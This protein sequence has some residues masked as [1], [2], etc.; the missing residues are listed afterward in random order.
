MGNL[1]SEA[2]MLDAARP[3]IEAG[4]AVHWLHP[5]TKRPVG[6]KWADKPVHTMES[7]AAAYQ[8]GYN[9]GVRPGAV[10]AVA[11]GYLHLVD[12]DIRKP[13][14]AA[15]AW[16]AL[17]AMWPDARLAPTVRSG[18]GGE[19]R[20]LYLITTK[21]FRT[22][23]LAKSEGWEM[24]Y[25]S[26][27]ERNVRKHDWEIEFF[28][29]AKQAVLPPSIHD[30][31]GLPYV[32]E[33]PLDFGDLL[34]IAP[35]VAPETVASWGASSDD[36]NLGDD[37]DDLMALYR[38]EPMGLSE[39][40]IAATLADL[41]EDWVED[42]DHWYQVGM[43]LHH[44][45]RGAD[46][47]FTRWCEWSKQ[48]EKFDLKDSKAVWRSFGK[49]AASTRNP[50]RMASL[51]QAASNHR[52][53]QGHALL[54]EV[55]TAEPVEIDLLAPTDDVADLLDVFSQP[56]R[57]AVPAPASGSGVV[58]YDPD[59]FQYLQRNEDGGIKPTVHNVELII[60][61]DKR[62]RG[63]I[64]Y[65]EF[66]QLLV[67]RAEPK[68]FA[69]RK[70]S[71]KPIRQLE[72]A[73]WR[74]SEER[75]RINGKRWTDVLSTDIRIILEAPE[76]QGGY[77]L[78]TSKRDLDEAIDKV[79]RLH[80]FHPIRDY[81]N[82]LT[83]D[84]K[85]RAAT[86]FVDYVGAEGND[87]HREAALMWLLG[88]V[89]RVFEPG[90]KFDFVPILEGAQGVRKS[91]FF[92]V[93]GRHWFAELEGDFHDAKGMVERMQGAWIIELPEL[94]G[95]S[96]AEVQTIKGFISRQSDIVRLAYARHPQ[97]FDR[98]CVMGGSTNDREYLRDAT[99][100]RRFWPVE[101]RVA[102][103][104][105][106]RLSA[107][108]DQIWAEATAMYRKMRAEQPYGTL[109]LF[110]KSQVAVDYAREIQESRRQ[111]GA[112]DALA[113][114]IE[115][116]LDSPIGSEDGLTQ[117]PGE[118]VRYRNRTCYMEIWEVM[119]GRDRHVYPDREA[120]MVGRAMRKV[121]GWVYG[122]QHRFAQY[123][124][125]RCFIREGWNGLD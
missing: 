78:K 64:G 2:E 35:V 14:A 90:H 82:S 23:K 102:S 13:E 24:V 9:L 124:K 18:S 28:G 123:G 6:E 70:E 19:S 30:K 31:T 10:S 100:A 95:F 113:A 112:D 98:Q 110:M 56:E 99:G 121:K 44:E 103:I 118:P 97:E 81:L 43:A 73:M 116:W 68:R 55:S 89:V 50:I 117:L 109:P 66:S 86:L 4:V 21:P 67:Q 16:D 58:E 120:Q 38:A 49:N 36:L 115:E 33:R 27:L 8:R 1:P 57:A 17:I 69:L 122:G 54:E 114:Q 34:G 59:W 72:G 7:L 60:R 39:N 93:L 71:P 106:S 62:L 29:T 85:H 101:C 53:A 22:R 15:A 3:L 105:T 107:E 20:H 77:G 125:Q 96:R 46:N 80:A 108:I 12:L 65:N 37:D 26:E 40:E 87:Y 42:R 83:W 32:W 79:A 45:Y 11:G 88:A 74:V 63:V 41:P 25:D 52:L 92:R 91:T 48:S 47:G 76:R 111:I 84:G 94:Q 61:N 5:R 119:M 51:I 104:D 75:H